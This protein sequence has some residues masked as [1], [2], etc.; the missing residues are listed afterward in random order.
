MT[1]NIYGGILACCLVVGIAEPN[2]QNTQPIAKVGSC[3]VEEGK[4]VIGWW[5]RGE[6]HCAELVGPK[7]RTQTNRF[8]P[9][10]KVTL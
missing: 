7:E 9:K 10:R 2:P 6:L 3:M 5:E 4:T 1:A 8:M